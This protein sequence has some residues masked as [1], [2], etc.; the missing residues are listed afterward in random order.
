MAQQRMHARDGLD[1]IEHGR[2]RRD[3]MCS[4]RRLRRL[5]DWLLSQRMRQCFKCGVVFEREM[6]AFIRFNKDEDRRNFVGIEMS[7]RITR[8]GLPQREPMRIR[9]A[10]SVPMPSAERRQ[11]VTFSSHIDGREERDFVGCFGYV[12]AA[13]RRAEFGSL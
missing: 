7:R 12:A 11:V 9:K 6:R 10:A 8:S 1:C 2:A 13:F 3:S 4:E 5:R